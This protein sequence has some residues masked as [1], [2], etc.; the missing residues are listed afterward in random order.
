MKSWGQ[1]LSFLL[2]HFTM[3]Y[4]LQQSDNNWLVSIKD[5]LNKS[6]E[7]VSVFALS[8]SPWSILFTPNTEQRI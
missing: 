7:H 8:T 4:F 5:E 2:S 3:K 1:S 6:V